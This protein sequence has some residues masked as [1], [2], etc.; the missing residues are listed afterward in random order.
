[1]GF[2]SDTADEVKANMLGWKTRSFAGFEVHHHRFTGAAHGP[3]GNSVK[4]GRTDYVVGY[5]PLFLL[6]KCGARLFRNPYVLG[7]LG[8]LYGY[9]S[10]AWRRLAR[11]DDPELIRYLRGQQLAR[12]CGRESIW[13]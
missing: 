13:R 4:D 6:A 2:G 11:I 8:L 5:H 7:S 3:W 9:V 12:L 10:S 1:M